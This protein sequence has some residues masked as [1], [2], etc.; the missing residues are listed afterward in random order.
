MAN[1]EDLEAARA[2]EKDLAGADLVG[3]DLSQLDLRR[4]NFSRAKLSQ[5][6]FDDANLEGA[7]FDGAELW[8]ATFGRA[9]CKRASFIGSLSE[10][11][12]KEAT[13]ENAS[14]RS[15]L[16]SHINFSSAD[17]RGADFFGAHFSGSFEFSNALAD[18][19]TNFDQ[20]VAPRALRKLE[21]FSEYTYREGRFYRKPISI[22]T[23]TEWSL[24]TQKINDRTSEQPDDAHMIAHVSDRE[25]IVRR[26]TARPQDVTKA[27]SLLIALIDD[28]LETSISDKPNEPDE[29]HRYEAERAFLEQIKSGLADL[30]NAVMAAV[31]TPESDARIRFFSQASEIVSSLTDKLAKWGKRSERQITETVGRSLILGPVC[32]F[33]GFCGVPG[34]IGFPLLYALWGTSISKGSKKVD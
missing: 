17:L 20:V 12:F 24:P 31:Q 33:L 11:T 5:S 18:G 19:N 26:V 14:F 21:I 28:H 30:Q 23:A 32:A 3:A 2:G 25:E 9:N 1:Q 15:G 16:L 13:L 27:V 7:I 4:C 29:L 22:S 34:S 10:V 8:R 6:V